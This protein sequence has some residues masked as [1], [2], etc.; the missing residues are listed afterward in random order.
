MEFIKG[1]NRFYKENEN[2][3]LIAEI[4]YKPIDEETIDADRTF[5]DESLRGKGVAEQ[6]VDRLVEEMK[7]EGKKIH[8]S[9]SYIV[10]LFER[11]EEK[12]GKIQA[13]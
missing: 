3:K 4:T 10:S 2:G 7:V 5:V 8:P 13:D 12:Y 6:L 11:K 9:C 1:E